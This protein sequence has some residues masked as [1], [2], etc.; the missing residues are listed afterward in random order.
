L[1]PRNY[2]KVGC[3]VYKILTTAWAL[4]AETKIKFYTLCPRHP[5]DALKSISIA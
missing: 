2:N 3:Q 4:H 1:C 5:K